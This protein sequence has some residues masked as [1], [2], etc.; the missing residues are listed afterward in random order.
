M[1]FLELKPTALRLLMVGA[2]IALT[3]AAFAA[4]AQLLAPSAQDLAG[5]Q[6][7]RVASPALELAPEQRGAVT[8]SFPVAAD[9]RVA[10]APTPF[11]AESHEF[12]VEVSAETLRRGTPLHLTAP[13]AVVRVHPVGPLLSAAVDST[14]FV[15][16]SEVGRFAAGTGMETLADA[17]AMA[18]AGVPFAA[19]TVAFRVAPEVGV[20]AVILSAPDLRARGTYQVHVFEPQSRIVLT[21]Q[22]AKV[23]YLHGE[24]LEVAATLRD[25]RTGFA[26]SAIE[27]YV[28]SPAG[29]AWT[30]PLNA[31][32]AGRYVGTLR[33]DA[34][35][36]A[37]PGLW[38]VHTAARGRV[39]GLEVARSERTSFGAHVP[40]ATLSNQVDVTQA[41]GRVEVGFEVAVATP[42]RF[43]V[44]ALLYGTDARG[45]L[46]PIASGHA[47][48]L[49]ETDGTLRLVFDREL[50]AASGLEAPFE[51]RDL[52]LV[53]Y[54]R[55]A[56]LH[57]Q[58]VALRIAD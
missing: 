21:L 12:F 38:E 45:Q 23:D 51:L 43:E 53:D 11:L 20:G 35:E 25:G 10:P 40:T 16:T 50:I 34:V 14:E 29:R 6:A 36:A 18:E 22:T 33:L 57:R 39:G 26:A 19:G 9:A 42:S 31:E 48:D 3:S 27:A 54:G 46:R 24:E 17:D 4:P 8:Y 37:A 49:L 1:T 2:S 52:R 28:T 13:G 55:L 47:A 41:R 32:G 7:V 58:A 15:L 30:L 56:T 5:G 44:R